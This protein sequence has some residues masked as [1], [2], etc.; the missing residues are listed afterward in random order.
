M[1]FSNMCVQDEN[2][3]KMVPFGKNMLGIMDFM[4]D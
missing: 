4:H 2:Q 3:E 1:E